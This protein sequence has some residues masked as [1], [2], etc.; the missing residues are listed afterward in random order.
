[1]RVLH[2]H[3]HEGAVIVVDTDFEDRGYLVTHLARDRAERGRASLRVENRDR[4]ADARTNIF[5]K[6]Y[7][8][9]DLAGTGLQG[10]HIAADRLLSQ[11]PQIFQRVASQED[12]LRAAVEGH[13]QRLFDQGRCFDDAGSFAD[14]LKHVFPVIQLSA[15]CLHDRMTVQAHDLVQQ[16]GAKTV[17]DAHHDDQH[18]HGEHDHGDGDACDKRD[19]CLAPA[20]KQV[21][22]GDGTFEWRKDQGGS[23]LSLSVARAFRQTNLATQ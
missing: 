5:R 18:G 6:P 19:E 10:V 16:F 23:C 22:F 2:R 13:Q 1:M 12:R 8:D 21:A 9:G 17:H 11:L 20:R 3:D 4:I 14:F 15:I 7:A